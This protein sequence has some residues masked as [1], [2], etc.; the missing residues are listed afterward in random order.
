[1]WAGPECSYLTV[2]EWVCDQLALTG[3]D[4]RTDDVER[5]ASLGVV[6]VR[7]P[8]LW[9]RSRD[10]AEA[11]DWAWA[12]DRLDRLRRAGIRPIVGLLHH[13]FGPCGQEP[14]DPGWP[15]AVGAFAAEV[16]RRTPAGT[17]FL[18]LNEPLTT[19][20]FG[21]LYGWWPPYARDAGVFASLLLAECRA[22]VE[23]TRAIRAVRPGAEIL[24]NEDVGR[25]FA[26]PGCREVARRH[27]DRRW[28]TFDLL[29]GRVDR[30][31]PAWGLLATSAARRRILAELGREPEAPDILGVDH[32]VTSDR[33]LDERL[34]RFPPSTHAEEDGRRYA[35]VEVVRVG[36]Q[37][38][39]GFRRAIADTWQRYGLP[40]ALT[41]VQLAGE[42]A[43][44]VCWW[45][46]AWEAASGAAAAGVPVR[47]VTA[48][49]VFGAY[50]WAS[51]LRQPQGTYEA[52]C[53]DVSGRDPVATP[54]A[55]VV[56][57]TAGVRAGLDATSTDARP[58]GW[59]RRPDRILYD[60]DGATSARSAA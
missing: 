9:G 50:E 52:G 32:Y 21:G 24:V 4:R 59:W 56:A 34:D 60:P 43:D 42:A 15:R 26:S 29:T 51:V 14:L 19:A 31:H 18:P 36:G 48:W 54:L 27:N 7:Y 28:L 33:Y 23:A 6:A 8:V 13:G 11:T 16:A 3:H 38:V 37:P 22:I 2:G 39:E 49:S 35:D 57:A 25:T 20:R 1:V 17:A 47:G 12:E 30:S 41:E 44:Q 46:E 53:W 5:L 55:D 10:D 40:I 58:A 45:L